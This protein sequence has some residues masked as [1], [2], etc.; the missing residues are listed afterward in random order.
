MSYLGE[1]L[2]TLVTALVA[3]ALARSVAVLLTRSAPNS[4]QRPVAPP[5]FNQVR[6]PRTAPPSRD[7]PRRVRPRGRC[8]RCRPGSGVVPPAAAP[9]VESPPVRRYPLPPDR[10][11]VPRSPSAAPA[12]A[13]KQSGAHI[14]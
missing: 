2:S 11:P 7:G 9:V 14:S 1:V 8:A 13:R 10:C 12:S 6:E 4:L 5:W 3:V